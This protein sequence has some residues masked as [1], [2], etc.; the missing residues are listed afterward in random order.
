MVVRNLPNRPDS[1]RP[2]LDR[3]LAHAIAQARDMVASQ[4]LRG[5]PDEH[6]SRSA[7]AEPPERPLHWTHPETAGNLSVLD[8]E[9]G[10]VETVA[11]KI[12]LKAKYNDALDPRAICTPYGWWQARGELGL[13]DTTRYRW[14]GPTSTNHPESYID[15]ISASMPHRSPMCRVMKGTRGG[16]ATSAFLANQPRENE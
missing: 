14:V 15:A 8:G 2:N 13:S 7:N 16:S 10:N 4:E 3:G 1:L 6:F 12:R 5:A 9:W 11:G